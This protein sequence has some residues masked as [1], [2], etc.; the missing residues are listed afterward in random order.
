MIIAN[1]L[2]GLGNQM[3]QYAF[4][5]ALSLR[6][7]VP[8]CL[9]VGDFS[10][11][12]LREY[13]LENV[14]TLKPVMASQADLRKVLG[15]RASS[16]ARRLLLK[17]RFAAF[18][19]EK[20]I[21]EPQ[22]AYWP[23]VL[24]APEDCYLIG[25]WVSEKYFKDFEDVIRADFSFK[26][27]LSAL[28]SGLAGQ[29]RACASVSLHIRR[30]DIANDPGTLAVHGLCSPEYYKRAVDHIVASVKEPEFFI[31]SDDIQWAKE[32]LSIGFKCHYVD[33]NKGADSFNDMRLMSLC[34]HHIIA[35]ST[36]SWW[37]AW[38]NPRADKIVLA[39]QRW[40]A[41]NLDSSDIVPRLWTRLSDAG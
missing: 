25:H 14:F 2:G 37:G 11:Y 16:L 36:F 1:C 21:I 4:G 3:F 33:H 41:A 5:R 39:P 7:K 22:V 17:K 40:F 15:L 8:F 26:T 18:R 32:N 13:Q 10:W 12:G 27:P 38:L 20:L 35:N 24:A 34:R 6:R 23:P 29:M 30:G 9:D 31:F 19:G 28:N